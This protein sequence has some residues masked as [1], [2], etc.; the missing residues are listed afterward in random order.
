MGCCPG[1]IQMHPGWD[2][3]NESGFE[4][5]H[6]K[7]RSIFA[8]SISLSLLN[9]STNYAQRRLLKRAATRRATAVLLLRKTEQTRTLDK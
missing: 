6:Y 9:A 8:T 1:G 7:S 5:V 4:L 3:I 2:P